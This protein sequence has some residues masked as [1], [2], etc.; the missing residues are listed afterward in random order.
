MSESSD[1]IRAQIL[2]VGPLQ[3]NCIVLTNGDAT[4]VIDPGADAVEIEAALGD[5]SLAAI[6]LTH[7]HYDHIGAV[8]EL[9]QAYPDCPVFCHPETSALAKDPLQ[10]LGVWICGMEYTLDATPGELQD[11][12]EFDQAGIRFRPYLVP[13]H[14]P[15]QMAFYCQQLGMLFAG[16]TVFAGGLGRSDF[17]GGD[18]EL[19]V[20]KTLEMLRDLPPE[21]IIW[22]GHG[23]STTAG[24]ELQRNP[25]LRG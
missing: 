6:L 25:Y 13:G 9:V 12:T 21:T 14:M 24:Q 17:P 11:R 8:N 7:A 18:G 19:L 2:V 22:P 10:N 5:K 15:G 16:D 3:V 23:P 1:S 4:V 20:R